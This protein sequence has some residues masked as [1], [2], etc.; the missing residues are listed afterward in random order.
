M[1][2]TFVALLFSLLVSSLSVNLLYID[3]LHKIDQNDSLNQDKMS[4]IIQQVHDLKEK[5]E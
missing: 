2:Y 5:T 1:K 4:I 3:M